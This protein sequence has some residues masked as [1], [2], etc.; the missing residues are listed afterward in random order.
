MFTDRKR[1]YRETQDDPESPEDMFSLDS[2]SVST[3]ASASHQ[4]IRYSQSQSQSLNR[5]LYNMN[6]EDEEEM[7]LTSNIIRYLLVADRSKQ[8][9]QKNHIIKHAL[10]G[11]AKLFRTVIERIKRHLSGVYSFYHLYLL[12][13][14]HILFIFL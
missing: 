6:M 12:I 10:N 11:N 1:R 7:Q 3:R 8:P 2:H 14:L 5:T 13:K 9:I 4:S